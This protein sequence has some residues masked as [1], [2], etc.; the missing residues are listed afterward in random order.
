MIR[1]F[2]VGMFG[3]SNGW[4]VRKGPVSGVCPWAL[5]S[6]TPYPANVAR[7]LGYANS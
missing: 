3:K 4:Q 2:S 6:V 7:E 5:D 1:H